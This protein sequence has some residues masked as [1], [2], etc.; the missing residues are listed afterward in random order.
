V[1]A[2]D[3]ANEAPIFTLVYMSLEAEPMS[4]DALMG[5]L[6]KAR[7]KNERLGI[8]GLLVHKAGHFLQ[9]LEG[10]RGTVESLM[11]VIAAD[12]RHRDVVVLVRE[13]G[14]ARHFGDWSMALADWP[15]EDVATT[16]GWELLLADIHGSGGRFGASGPVIDFA[17]SLAHAG[18]LA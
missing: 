2:T 16:R 12:A 3:D 6:E 8:T 14:G 13:T 11:A 15:H 18:Y 1:P 7:A 5:L 9:V 4:R 17:R 10:Q